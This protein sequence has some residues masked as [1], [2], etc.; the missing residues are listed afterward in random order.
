MS[1]VGRNSDGGRIDEVLEVGLS[2][3]K[4]IMVTD[5]GIRPHQQFTQ[6]PYRAGKAIQ[7]FLLRLQASH[8]SPEYLVPMGGCEYRDYCDW[9]A[10]R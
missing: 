6:G 8:R 7:G 9:R 2:S 1:K 4:K 3:R 5:R 10:S